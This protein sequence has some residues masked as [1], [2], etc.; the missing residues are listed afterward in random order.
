[1][2]T[3]KKLFNKKFGRLTVIGEEPVKN[4]RTYWLCLC[5]CGNKKV[6]MGKVLSAGLVKS[7][8]CLR[9]ESMGK[10]NFK[11]G[12]SRTL[13][14]HRLHTIWA[15]IRK[16]CYNSNFWAYKYYGGRGIKVCP[17]WQKYINF[18]KDLIASY[19]A[20]VK[21]FGIKNTTIDRINNDGNY[22]PKNCKWATMKEQRHNRSK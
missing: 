9:R 7:C 22:S 10:V 3:R 20:H 2:S 18:H 11:H 12:F 21:K 15:D 4:W 8:G 14:R 16:R 6:I 5:T 13:S 17:R 1:M 19:E